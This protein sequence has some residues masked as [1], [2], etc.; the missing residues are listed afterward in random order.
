M[1]T[2]LRLTALQRRSTVQVADRAVLRVGDVCGFVV[3]HRNRLGWNERGF[4]QRGVPVPRLL[5]RERTAGP[6]HG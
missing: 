2:P 5:W 3:E 1:S 6:S 4:V